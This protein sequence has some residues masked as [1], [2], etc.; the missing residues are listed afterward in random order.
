[1][2]EKILDTVVVTRRFQV[3]IT[4]YAR[5]VLPVKEGDRLVFVK[6]NGDLVLRKT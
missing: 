5:A 3:T 1:M 2:P 6:K 4:Q